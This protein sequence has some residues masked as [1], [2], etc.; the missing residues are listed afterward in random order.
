MGDI[1]D[2]RQLID[3]AVKLAGRI[4]ETRKAADYVRHSVIKLDDHAEAMQAS[5]VD[6]L[7]RARSALEARHAPAPPTTRGTT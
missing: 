7:G 3:E 5:L 6:L 4:D 1:D 2:A